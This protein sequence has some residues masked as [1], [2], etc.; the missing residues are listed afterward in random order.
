MTKGDLT[1]QHI[2]KQAATLFNQRGYAGSSLSDI[3]SVTGLQKGGIYRHFGSKEELALAAFDYAQQQSTECL[4]AAAES[5]TDAIKQLLA[6]AAAFHRLTLQPPIPGGCP[7]LNT[8]IDND[9]GDP[10]LLLRARSVVARWEALIAEIVVRGQAA[11]SVR[12]A[13]E[14]KAVVTVIIGTLEGAIMLSRAHRDTSYIEHAF[15]H[16]NDYIRQQV[17]V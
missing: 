3:M 5:E 1:R 7:I 15:A 17:A 13:V 16:I 8:V 6:V 9:D 10:A 2:I 4:V 11:G 14:P 12:T